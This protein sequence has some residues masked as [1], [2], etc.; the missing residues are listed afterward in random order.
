MITALSRDNRSSNPNSRQ[1][2]PAKLRANQPWRD[3]P[4]EPD[5]ACCRSGSSGRSMH[6]HLFTLIKVRGCSLPRG[7]AFPASHNPEL[8]TFYGGDFRR[9]CAATLGTVRGSKSFFYLNDKLA[10][11]RILRILPCLE[12]LLFAIRDVFEHCPSSGFLA[13]KAA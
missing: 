12:H 9:D 1:T 5:G 3:V 2:P 13:P 7:V 4:S 8:G 10:I 6:P 11:L